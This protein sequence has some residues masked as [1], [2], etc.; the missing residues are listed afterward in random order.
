VCRTEP[1]GENRWD[2]QDLWLMEGRWEEQ[3]KSQL[4]GSRFQVLVD[5]TGEHSE[6]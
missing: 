1:S 2:L 6:V 5:G 3:S 4:I